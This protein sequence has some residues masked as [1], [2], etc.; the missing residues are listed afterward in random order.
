MNVPWKALFEAATRAPAVTGFEQRLRQLDR[1]HGT[2]LGRRCS[3]PQL[4]QSLRGEHR[5]GHGCA[6]GR[7][8]LAVRVF[9]TRWQRTIGIDDYLVWHSSKSYVAAIGERLPEFLAAERTSMLAT[10]PDG[11]ITEPFEVR[12]VVAR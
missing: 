10:F 9:T 8:G 12:L 11:V 5:S 3:E 7:S 2:R 6:D 1:S 4:E